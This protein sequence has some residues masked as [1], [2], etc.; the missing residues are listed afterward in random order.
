M[1]KFKKSFKEFSSKLNIP[2]IRYIPIS[3]LNGDN[4]VEQSKEMDWYKGPTL[5]Y[6]LENVQVNHDFNHVDC[7]FPVQ[8]VIRPNTDEFHDFRG[9]AGRVE[10]GVF[11]PGD[12]VTALPSGFLAKSNRFTLMMVNL[13]KLTL[14]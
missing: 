12:E 4:V 13:M 10:G 7:R 2:D 8:Y 11:K 6:T 3:A 9:Y 14:R 5:L 1:K